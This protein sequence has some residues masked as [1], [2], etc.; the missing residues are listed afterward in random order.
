MIN[1]PLTTVPDSALKG[2]DQRKKNS[3][4]MTGLKAFAT[5]PREDR[6]A[7]H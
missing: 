5:T 1:S 6:I 4:A 7:G 2:S 3:P